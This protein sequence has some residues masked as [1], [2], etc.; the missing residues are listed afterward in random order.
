MLKSLSFGIGIFLLV[1]GLSLHTIDSYTV[2]ASAAAQATGLWG[3]P[4]QPQ[5]KT[6]TPEPWKPWVYIGSGVILM[7]WTVTLPARMKGK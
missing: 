7:L 4:F 3:G 6:I 2:R 1:L 5:A